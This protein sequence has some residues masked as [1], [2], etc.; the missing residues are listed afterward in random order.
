[1]QQQTGDDSPRDHSI[2]VETTVD[3]RTELM[4]TLW[5]LAGG[6]QEYAQKPANAEYIDE[7]ME[8]FGPFREHP[9]VKLVSTVQQ[10]WGLQW[11]WPCT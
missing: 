1:M 2:P 7:V 4:S 5:R 9:C 6:R 11:L 10:R 8:H 3:P